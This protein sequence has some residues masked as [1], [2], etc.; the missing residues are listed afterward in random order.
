MFVDSCFIE[1]YQTAVLGIR[2]LK[3]TTCPERLGVLTQRRQSVFLVKTISPQ[4]NKGC[5]NQELLVFSEIYISFEFFELIN[6]FQRQQRSTSK[7]MLNIVELPLFRM[8]LNFLF[9]S[10]AFFTHYELMEYYTNCKS[11]QHRLNL[12]SLVQSFPIL[13]SINYI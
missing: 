10:F 4:F 13:V 1:E 5:G 11:E 3:L 6:Y 7:D 8:E 2:H 9:S 12:E